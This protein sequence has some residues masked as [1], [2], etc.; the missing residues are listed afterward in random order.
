MKEQLLF[1]NP[2]LTEGNQ[3][4]GRSDRTSEAM[5]IKW[6]KAGVSRVRH[7]L[8]STKGVLLTPLEF[9]SRYAKLE[10]WAYEELLQV[11]PPE[12]DTALRSSARTAPPKERWHHHPDGTIEREVHTTRRGQPQREY[13]RVRGADA[14]LERTGQPP[15]TAASEAR[16]CRVCKVQPEHKQ[17]RK[18]IAPAASTTTGGPAALQAHLDKEYP[19]QLVA[20][21][22]E[23]GSGDLRALAAQPAQTLRPRHPVTVEDM[24]VA[25]HSQIA[26]AKEWRMP[27]SFDPCEPCNHYVDE[28]A[29]LPAP[30]FRRKIASIAKAAGHP[31]LEPAMRELVTK[32]AVSAL[33]MGEKVR[34]WKDMP[35]KAWQC[36]R[37]C[38]RSHET[39]ETLEHAFHDDPHVSRL[40]ED[41]LERWH[42]ATGEELSSAD[43]R[44][45]M[46]G[47]RGAHAHA[48]T[49]EVW[50]ALH[51]VTLGVIN[52]TREASKLARTR[53][54]MEASTPRAMARRVREELDKLAHRRER[55]Q[56]KAGRSKQ[57]EE[58]WGEHLARRGD[59]W[60]VGLLDGANHE[61]EPGGSARTS[62]EPQAQSARAKHV[63]TD[64][65]YDMH[66]KGSCAGWAYIAY[67]ESST[68]P[69]ASQ[70][71]RLTEA[72]CG[73]VATS[74]N[75]QGYVGARKH[76]NNTGEL[77][78][79]LHAVEDELHRGD[80][81]S[82]VTIHVDSHQ[83]VRDTHG[84]RQV[85][86]QKGK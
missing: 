51:A 11:M 50:R 13:Y 23:G 30:E 7:V 5:A 80:P 78:A 2:H 54:A 19:Y 82:A 35:P 69:R 9:R 56:R 32:V 86:R 83:P 33:P 42:A 45:T 24:T 72:R 66:A 73:R 75:T 62:A 40:W 37:A 58:D 46:L 47:D 71:L 8:H 27:R 36:R 17:Q 43:K 16:P 28:Y 31:V 76:S 1:H 70:V 61:S 38:C 79:L 48:A 68:T 18:K 29:A 67:E 10:D 4:A 49:E 44:V 53:E 64:G 41:T 26:T 85:A 21:A 34:R 77:T 74:A 57:F 81:T 84:D 55:R 14:R 52:R 65:S 39:T 59:E 20:P 3:F 25:R 22:R 63:Y 15:T 6:A 60:R 12:W